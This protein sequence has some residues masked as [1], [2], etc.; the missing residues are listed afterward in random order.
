VS[1]VA[2]SIVL[3]GAAMR[4][5]P[6]LGE[7]APAVLLDEKEK[8]IALRLSPLPPPPPDPT[9]AVADDPA[10]ARLGPFLF[11][12]TRL[13]ANGRLACVSCHDPQQGF[14]D[15]KALAEGLRLGRRHAATL[16]NVAYNRWF[17]WDGRA[18]TLWSQALHPLESPNELG[19]S[20]L[21][22]AHLVFRE[23][24]L[25]A[26]YERLFGALPDLSDERRF[27]AA[28]RPMPGEPDHPHHRA[29]TAM[30]PADQE[31]V[32]RIFSNMA[33]CL[34]A[35][36]RRL[37]SRQAPFDRFVEGLR[38]GDRAGL[39]A[40]SP[41]A[42]RGLQVFI[43]DGNCRL[44]HS[45]PNFTDG[46]FHDTRVPSAD[47]GRPG[48]AGRFAGAEEVLRDPFNA[49][50]A[51]SDERQ[52]PAAQKLSFLSNSPQNWGLFKTPTLRNVTRTAPYMHQ[53][54]KQTL[55]EVLQHYSTFEGAQADSHHPENIL[56]PLRL[57]PGEID[58]LLAFL[59][60]LTDEAL[61]AELLRPPGSPLPEP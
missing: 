46:E 13:S 12:D 11:F 20:R 22:L 35:Y 29:W 41:S 15:G 26:A 16:W 2:W 30:A 5:L 32:D 1:G 6:A 57:D 8:G 7:G 45:G 28:G 27:P 24:E 4:A 58:D 50:G 10:A 42:Q 31:L 14:A 37:V 36:E 54:Q 60:S 21:E 47:G 9:N 25:R 52:G 48:D 43:G 59:E 53:G 38:G 56:V 40:L 34:A 18:D 61:P 44:C 49:A 33:K 19:S 55:R 17:F 23:R 51:Y 39:E 3:C